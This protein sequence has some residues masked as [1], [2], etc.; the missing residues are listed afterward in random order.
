MVIWVNC[1]LFCDILLNL[2]PYLPF[3]FPI[4][5]L[6]SIQYHYNVTRVTDIKINSKM[7]LRYLVCYMHQPLTS[8]LK[9][10]KKVIIGVCYSKSLVCGKPS[11]EMANVYN[12]N[13]PCHEISNN[14]VCATSK[15]SDQ[16]PH[17]RSLIRAFASR[18]NFLRQLSY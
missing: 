3:S 10:Y 1:L 18:L 9:L 14:V 16:P 17:K 6:V 4:I 12:A 15:G 2:L 5:C 8:H 7:F 11:L 13:E